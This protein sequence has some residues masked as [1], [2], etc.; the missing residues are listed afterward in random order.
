MY[1]VAYYVVFAMRNEFTMVSSKKWDILLLFYIA[2]HD[3]IIYLSFLPPRVTS[4]VYRYK[5]VYHLPLN[6]YS[7]I[8]T[9]EG[10]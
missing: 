8:P 6:I 9:S 7:Q 4:N 5:Y 1:V 3:T 2:M 10:R